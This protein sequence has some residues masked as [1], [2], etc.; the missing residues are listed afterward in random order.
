[1]NLSDCRPSVSR[2]GA[3]SSTTLWGR[4]GDQWSVEPRMHGIF[5]A[6]QAEQVRGAARRHRRFHL[7]VVVYGSRVLAITWTS[8]AKRDEGLAKACFVAEGDGDD[9]PSPDLS[10]RPTLSAVAVARSASC[11]SVMPSCPPSPTPHP[12][13]SHS[14][15]GVLGLTAQAAK[16]P[17]SCAFASAIFRCPSTLP[18]CRRLC[19]KARST[20]SNAWPCWCPPSPARSHSP[21][22]TPVRMLMDLPSIIAF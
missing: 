19:A 5:G 12:P 14:H 16:H 3:R 22:L 17:S 18:I 7:A 2:D 21:R 8:M 15:P 1:M 4:C 9:G 11:Y 13:L 10:T 6:G 20:P